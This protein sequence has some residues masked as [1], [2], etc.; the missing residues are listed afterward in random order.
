M[1]SFFIIDFHLFSTLQIYPNDSLHEIKTTKEVI[2]WIVQRAQ[3]TELL[4]N[5]N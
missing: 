4:L 2:K 3:T 5:E 1:N